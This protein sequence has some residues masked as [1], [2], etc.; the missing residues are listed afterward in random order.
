M[1]I[2]LL[3]GLVLGISLAAIFFLLISKRLSNSERLSEDLFSKLSQKFPEIL[4]QANTNLINLANEKIG[5]D[6]SNKKTAIED[7]VKRVLEELNKNQQKLETAETA[8]VSS[9]ST[10]S[11][12]LEEQRQ[13][14]EQLKT[15]SEGL[16]RV[17]TNNQL[18]GQFGEQVAEDLLKASGFVAGVNYQKQQSTA[19]SSRPDFT[20]ILPDGTKV[21][22]DVKFP[23]SNLVKMSETE[24]QHQK[25]QYLKSFQQDIRNKI[26]EVSGR[27]YINPED[28]T[29]DF[30]IL[31][32]P[33][34]MIFSFIYERLPDV[35]QEALNRKVILAG[36]FSFTAILRMVYQSYDNF[37]FQKDIQ[38]IIG[39][40]KQ[41]ESEFQK[42]NEEFQKIG[43]KIESLSKQY[44]SVNTTRTRQL[45]RSVD[46]IPETLPT[47]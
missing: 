22:I 35:R 24:D 42:Y 21:N 46:R 41:F 14:T 9:F 13:I 10:L 26:K 34:E 39:Q 3:A 4:N 29:V 32:I 31:F 40:I 47:G 12:R 8:R 37:R 18:R 44:E 16:K 2:Y 45:L 17:L 23:Y 28:K 30:V 19:S 36:P 20:V 25:D 38:L 33:N 1:I 43:D 15:T 27:E 5:T 6:L 7:M 11:Q